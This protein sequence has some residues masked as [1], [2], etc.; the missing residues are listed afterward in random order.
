MT[1]TT[2]DVFDAIA[3]GDVDRVRKLVA[4]DPSVAGARDA[5]DLSAVTQ[6]RYHGR[7]DIVDVLLAAEPELNVFEAAAV[8]RTQ[9]VRELIDADP[10][11]VAAFSPDGFT[12]LH[13]AAFFGHADIARML[14]ERGADTNAVARN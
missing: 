1:M 2:S 8:G 12:G 3:E 4:E 7:G 9:R 13:L 6:A 5:G 11:L 14:V 10:S